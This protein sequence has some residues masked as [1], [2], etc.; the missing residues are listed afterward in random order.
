MM[1]AALTGDPPSSARE[2]CG[3]EVSRWWPSTRKGREEHTETGQAV[4]PPPHCPRCPP[5][6]LPQ[7]RQQVSSWPSC[8]T[9]GQ[10]KELPIRPGGRTECRRASAGQPGRVGGEILGA[11]TSAPRVPDP[12]NP[13]QARGQRKPAQTDQEFANTPPAVTL[14][15][16]ALQGKGRQQKW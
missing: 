16:H 15:E 4:G 6:P 9:A 2:A 14:L 13:F 5:S 12:E 7:S 10:K 1:P 11:E 8:E 3:G